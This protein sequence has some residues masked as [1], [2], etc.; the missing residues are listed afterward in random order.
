MQFRHLKIHQ[1]GTTKRQGK[2][3]FRKIRESRQGNSKKGVARRFMAFGLTVTGLTVAGARRTHQE[4]P[5][6]PGWAAGIA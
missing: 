2:P 4:F 6:A 5:E 1:S 3:D